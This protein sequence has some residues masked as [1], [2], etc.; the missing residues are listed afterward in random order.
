MP[1]EIVHRLGFFK[2]SL[3]WLV[4]VLLRLWYTTLRLR[5]DTATKA[6]LS[7]SLSNPCVIY[8]WHR[9]LF[10]APMLRQLRKKRVMYGLIS[11]SKDGAWLDALTRW[12][13]VCGIRGSSTR[14]GHT[15]LLELEQR[16]HKNCD[17]IITPDGPKGPPCICKEGSLRWACQRKFTVI[18]LHLEM[19]DA[20]HL[21]S[22]DEFR[23]PKPF[24]AIRVAA[25]MF[26]TRNFSPE[27]LYELVQR[28]L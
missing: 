25:M 13:D 19:S 4:Y 14:R 20:W 9:N 27:S 22:W 3:A 11:A 28:G 17:V 1:E 24:S 16:A 12:F 23:I 18:A 8:F 10:V 2:K 26:D 6:V 15:A 21:R 5:M 7:T